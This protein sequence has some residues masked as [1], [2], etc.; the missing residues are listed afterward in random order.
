[1][2][3]NL[4]ITKGTV[5]IP[6]TRSTSL[7]V[8]RQTKDG[9]AAVVYPMSSTT[10]FSA[11]HGFHAHIV[12]NIKMG[13]IAA[14]DGDLLIV[15]A[16]KA[17]KFHHIHLRANEAAPYNRLWIDTGTTKAVVDKLMVEGRFWVEG[18]IGGEVQLT[19]LQSGRPAPVHAEQVVQLGQGEEATITVTKKRRNLKL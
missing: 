1:M 18:E 12:G 2:T 15:R 6:G 4:I 16:S 5:N 13:N 3:Q 7:E 19:Q 8:L 14:H 17:D 11:G 9:K 10:M